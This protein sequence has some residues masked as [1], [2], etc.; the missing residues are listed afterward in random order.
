MSSSDVKFCSSCFRYKAAEL[1]ETVMS[2]S[3]KRKMLRCVHCKQAREAAQQERKNR[4]A[5]PLTPSE[6]EPLLKTA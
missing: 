3:G 5:N 2:T 6:D 4:K 1:V